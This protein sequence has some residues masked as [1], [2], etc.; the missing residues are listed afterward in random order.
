MSSTLKTPIYV[1]GSPGYDYSDNGCVVSTC[2]SVTGSVFG[3][4]MSSTC[5]VQDEGICY[6]GSDLTSVGGSADV[7]ACVSYCTTDGTAVYDALS[8]SGLISVYAKLAAGDISGYQNCSEPLCNN[9]TL[10]CS[11]ASYSSTGYFIATS[12]SD[13]LCS[14]VNASTVKVYSLGTC[15]GVFVDSSGSLKDVNPSSGMSITNYVVF[16][17]QSSPP[18]LIGNL[19]DLSDSTCSGITT[20]K[21]AVYTKIG[22]ID[23]KCTSQYKYF[24]RASLDMPFNLSRFLPEGIDGRWA[25]SR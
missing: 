14:S 24:Y 17:R 8:E 13:S 5:P 22:S 6:R 1:T 16:I 21:I 25:I 23:G 10:T 11:K 20:G 4:V 12:Y 19:Y 15:M 18:A 3:T 2:Q 7:V 9:Q